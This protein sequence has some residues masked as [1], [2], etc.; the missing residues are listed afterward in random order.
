MLSEQVRNEMEAV[1]AIYGVTTALHWTITMFNHV[2]GY[3]CSTIP[4]YAGRLP[5]EAFCLED[6]AVLRGKGASLLVLTCCSR[7]R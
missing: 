7:L 4:L 2:T 1:K 3:H 6:S 5:R